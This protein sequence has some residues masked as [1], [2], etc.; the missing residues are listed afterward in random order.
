M[1]RALDAS[2]S[3][4]SPVVAVAKRNTKM[5]LLTRERQQMTMSARASGA[6][7]VNDAR[8][9]LVTENE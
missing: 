7:I 3:P 2:F 6:Y 9:R 1:R 4:D 8:L 5:E